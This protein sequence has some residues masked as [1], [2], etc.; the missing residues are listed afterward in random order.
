MSKSRKILSVI[1]CL[2]LVAGLLGGWQYIA[3][4]TDKQLTLWYDEPAIAKPPNVSSSEVDYTW[5]EWSLPVGNGYMGASVFGYTDVERIQITES[6]KYNAH[7]LT[8]FAELYLDFQ[9]DFDQVTDYRRY[10]NLNT[11][12]AGVEY[13]YGGVSYR[14]E[15]FT[16][17]PDKVLV[18]RLTASQPGA[19]SFRMG[20]IAPYT[21]EDESEINTGVAAADAENRRVTLWG[22]QSY[23]DID[24]AG[25]FAITDA[26][27]GAQIT[28]VND[29]VGMGYDMSV[30]GRNDKDESIYRPMESYGYLE[31]SG[32]TQVE[33]RAAVGT[34]YEMTAETVSGT[35]KG[36]AAVDTNAVLAKVNGYIA[37][38]AAY[39]YDQLW[40]RHQADYRPYFERVQLD[41]GAAFPAGYTTDQI[42]EAYQNYKNKG[43]QTADYAV[44]Q[45]THT[46]LETLY[47]QYGRYLYIASSRVGCLPPG[48]Q[49]I[50]CGREVAAWTGGYWSNI[51]VQMNN[52]GAF[53]NNLGDLFQSYADYFLCGLES[54]EQAADS[55]V[56]RNYPD[57]VA[58]LGTG[59]NGWN[60][61]TD[62]NPYRVTGYTTWNGHSG[63]GNAGMTAYLF[64]EWYQYTG[65]MDILRDTV[66]PV[67]EG[68]AKFFTK[69]AQ[70][71]DGKYYYTH[72]SSPENGYNNGQEITGYD[73]QSFEAVGA[74]VL[75]A[76]ELL[77]YT[78]ADHPI[79][80]LL[81]RQVGSYD[82]VVVGWSGQVKE[83]FSETYYGDF[84]EYTH[85]HISHLMGLYPYSVI[86]EQTE[87]WLDAATVTLNERG[88]SDNFFTG[89]GISH[90]MELWARAGNGDRVYKLYQDLLSQRT[91]HNLWDAH[92]PF[93]ID[94]NFGSIAGLAECF[95][96]SNGDSIRLLPALG[97]QWSSGSVRGLMARGNFTVAAEWF[98]ARATRFE[99]TSNGGGACSL[100]Y[101]N[102]SGAAIETADGQ[103]VAF[104]ATGKD[105]V[106]F[107]TTAGET[108][109]VTAIPQALQVREINALA[110]KITEAGV[111]LQWTDAENAVNRAPAVSYNVYCAVESEPN[112]TLI[113]NTA[114]QTFVDTAPAQAHTAYRRYKIKAVSADGRESDGVWIA[115]LPIDDFAVTAF[116]FSNG[117][118]QLQVEENLSATAYEIYK[119]TPQGYEKLGSFDT[120]TV[121]IQNGAGAEYGAAVRT[122]SIV[123]D[124]RPATL[125][126]GEGVSNI[127]PG[128]PAEASV[129]Q[130]SG[131]PLTNLNDGSNATVFRPAGTG[132]AYSV[133][134]D[135]GRDFVLSG[136]SIPGVVPAGMVTAEVY[137]GTEWQP[138]LQNAS[139]QTELAFAP[140]T[141]SKLRITLAGEAGVYPELAEL[142][143][144]GLLPTL[145]VRDAAAPVIDS[146]SITR[147]EDRVTVT[148]HTHVPNS[149]LTVRV[150]D[151]QGGTVYLDQ[152]QSGADGVYTIDFR[153]PETAAAG[154]YRLAISEA[155]YETFVLTMQ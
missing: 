37:D 50:W 42:L 64:W 102:L 119:K 141:G 78:A 88:D 117:D 124:I 142:R 19:L 13:T 61:G 45:Q 154:T 56:Y 70:E 137:T 113:G 90:R 30:I 68:Y 41:L 116:T 54:L 47:Y 134:F 23:Y 93:Q 97:S 103:P 67:I 39:T 135:L 11:A 120:E 2:T 32:A 59:E 148:G 155:H 31:V 81:Q 126:G 75:Q 125:L 46:Y 15:I 118:V 122:G 94:G 105:T 18:I 152:L 24:F 136:L 91:Y 92:A 96:Q 6:S 106:T 4:E 21:K 33:I 108:Y 53:V 26:D 89:W 72:S 77:G 8:D 123:S 62:C 138:V 52:W 71:R 5:A 28:A 63:V 129:G 22:N 143:V 65:D 25:S 111:A 76:A 29:A 3:A 149:E 74:A 114:E 51:N 38:T 35:H 17:Y 100:T 130:T 83:Y 73:Q 14:R 144:L 58:Q 40:D 98:N 79:L 60:L 99:I 1:L 104:T 95:V 69:I 146:G 139:L 115:L 147:R 87:A 9:H 7:G 12:A 133:E 128:K 127:L 121:R 57:T 82:P 10:L 112:Y 27:A 16:S 84:G 153:M 131:F 44:Y 86:N 34:D 85:R 132:G 20:A 66:Y 80:D 101:D 49:G 145:P 110:L 36:N 48:L 107:S 55:F 43:A 151:A 150:T 109:V 140:V